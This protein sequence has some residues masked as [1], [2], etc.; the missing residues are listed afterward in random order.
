MLN[1]ALWKYLPARPEVALDG[2]W[3]GDVALYGRTLRIAF[4]VSQENGLRASFD[5]LPGFTGIPVQ[6]ITLHQDEIRFHVRVLGAQ[7][8][9]RH[10][11]LADRLVG[12][13]IV[14]ERNIPITLSRTN[15][16][17]RVTPSQSLSPALAVAG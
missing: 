16:L 3:T 11:R 14:G 17:A 5:C 6:A 1:F 12:A 2:D 8:A 4:H 9:G 7:F 13:L 10:D 15:A